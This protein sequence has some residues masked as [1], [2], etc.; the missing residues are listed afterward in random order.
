MDPATGSLVG[1]LGGLLIGLFWMFL[2]L[3]GL[4]VSGSILAA[5]GSWMYNNIAAVKKLTDLSSDTVFYKYPSGSADEYLEA[6]KD[7]L[8]AFEKLTWYIATILGVSFVATIDN[9]STIKIPGIDVPVGVFGIVFYIVFVGCLIYYIK[10]VSSIQTLYAGAPEKDDAYIQIATHS[11][12]LSPFSENAGLVGKFLDIFGF[13]LLIAVWWIAFEIATRLSFSN[14]HLANTLIEDWLPWIVV[15]LGLA[16]LFT[17]KE[18][19]ETISRSKALL[20]L[21]LL[22]AVLSMPIA[23]Y[24]YKTL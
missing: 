10:I 5:I 21:K 18:C 22:S 6:I 3:L 12:F 15:I 2:G 11:G 8:N 9:V 20:I 7:R 16:A 17:T 14:S 13:S 19:M 23:F 4:V 24:V 1:G